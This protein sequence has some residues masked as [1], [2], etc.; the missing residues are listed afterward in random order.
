MKG[1]YIFFSEGIVFA[2]Y[3][4]A[5]IFFFEICLQDIFSEIAYNPPQK[6]NSRLLNTV[7]NSSMEIII[8]QLSQFSDRKKGNLFKTLK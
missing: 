1:I 7:L 6:S 4:L 5:R 3:F 2:R 8:S